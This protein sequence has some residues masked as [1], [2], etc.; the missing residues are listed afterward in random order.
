MFLKKKKAL[1]ARSGQSLLLPSPPG[2]APQ[3]PS[4]PFG[5]SLPSPRSVNIIS[6]SFSASL[7]SQ[8]VT[9]GA[10]TTG[11]AGAEV[12]PHQQPMVAACLKPAKASP[13]CRAASAARTCPGQLSLYLSSIFLIL[14]LYFKGEN[15]APLECL[16]PSVFPFA[17]FP[18]LP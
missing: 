11:L 8:V 1:A 4:P 14:K 2:M 12:H 5:H 9:S 6:P 15:P 10:L 18:S 3:A 17:L 16:P 7:S 13:L